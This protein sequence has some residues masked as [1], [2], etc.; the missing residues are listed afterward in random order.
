MPPRFS[1]AYML[2]PN[3]LNSVPRTFL[4][5][6][7]VPRFEKKIINKDSSWGASC[8]SKTH[9]DLDLLAVRV[10]NGWVIAFYPNVLDELGCMFHAC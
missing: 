4:V 9:I 8:G 1:H 3:R 10:F 6:I 2:H 5:C 7:V